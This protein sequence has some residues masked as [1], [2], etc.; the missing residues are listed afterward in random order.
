MERV[1]SDAELLDIP[2]LVAGK[3]GAG[4]GLVIFVC[5][6]QA[7]SHE[8]RSRS[9]VVIAVWRCWCCSGKASSCTSCLSNVKAPFGTQSVSAFQPSILITPIMVQFTL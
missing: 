7:A 2:G 3:P 9:G 4:V 1:A 5:L 8:S 6:W